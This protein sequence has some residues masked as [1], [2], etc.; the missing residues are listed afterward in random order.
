MKNR[1]L[2]WAV[3]VGLIVVRCG[4]AQGE[5][6]SNRAESGPAPW[7]G[8]TSTIEDGELRCPVAYIKAVRE[9]GGVPVIIPVMR[10]TDLQAEYL[11]RLDGLV[12]IGGADVPAAAYGE[13]PHATLHEMPEAR[14]EWERRLVRLWLQSEKPLLGVCLGAQLTN[15][16]TG[17]TL[18][19]DIPSQVGDEVSHRQSGGVRHAVT[20]R[21][22]SR[23]REILGA[24][25]LSV[26][27]SH[28]QAVR[29]V[30]KGLEV[31]AR[32]DDGVVEALEMPGDRWILL[33]QWHPE[34]MDRPHREAVYGALV[35]ACEA[36]A[37]QKT[38]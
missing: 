10:D 38:R 13:K 26:Y 36:A 9:A 18:I 3:V 11:N 12:L 29:T 17:G 21:P 30:G 16:V 1:L 8:V 22:G 6:T 27:S 7:I 34:Q 20:I 23:L 31:V 37:V 4:A 19:Q 25:R 35:E 14:W 2:S 28:H 24:D 15:V 33:L 5:D 32:S